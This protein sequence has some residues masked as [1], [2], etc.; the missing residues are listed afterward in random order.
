MRNWNWWRKLKWK[1]SRSARV[2]ATENA[3]TTNVK[4]TGCREGVKDGTSM[5]SVCESAFETSKDTRSRVLRTTRAQRVTRKLKSILMKWRFQ[6]CTLISTRTCQQSSWSKP[7][8]SESLHNHQKRDRFR[9]LPHQVFDRQH[10]STESH[11][12][13]EINGWWASYLN[14]YAQ[15]SGVDFF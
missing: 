6:M 2:T 15:I 10:R 4:T 8:F 1:V 9:K 11:L 5:P 7:S 3:A 12:K 13:T 14:K